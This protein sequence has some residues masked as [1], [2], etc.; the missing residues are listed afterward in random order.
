M[1][2]QTVINQIEKMR[3]DFILENKAALKRFNKDKQKNKEK[4]KD[5][6]DSII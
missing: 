4:G 6:V 5:Y 2:L 3:K 1:S